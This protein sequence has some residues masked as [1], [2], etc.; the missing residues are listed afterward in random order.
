MTGIIDGLLPNINDILGVRDDI[1]A[2]LKPVYL[3]TRT[4]QGAEPSDGTSVDVVE[5]VLPSPR[6]VE[7]SDAYKIREGGAVQQ[8][9]IMLKAVSKQTYPDKSVLDGSVDE[10]NVEKFFKVGDVLYRVIN[11]REKFFTYEIQLRRVS[12]Q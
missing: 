8:G 5:Q 1:G 3:V 4:W 9:D 7:L 12:K 2:A 6:I 11:V 10:Q